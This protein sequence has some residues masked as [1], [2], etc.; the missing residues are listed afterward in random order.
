MAKTEEYFLLET[1]V[2]DL[3]KDLKNEHKTVEKLEKLEEGLE[4]KLFKGEGSLS[5]QIHDLKKEVDE[6]RSLKIL[7]E[8]IKDIRRELNEV[9]G[10]IQNTKK[11]FGKVIM[12]VVFGLLSAIAGALHI[13][14]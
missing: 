5:T 7:P 9:E 2:H 4:E 8:Q 14:D 13:F 6:L 1:R 12:W 3:E 11:F 10:L